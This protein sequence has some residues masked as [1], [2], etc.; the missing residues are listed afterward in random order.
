MLALVGACEAQEPAD[1]GPATT[2]ATPTTASTAST[3][4]T[5]TTTATTTTTSPTTT[6]TSPTSST[7]ATTDPEAAAGAPTVRC[8]SPEGYSVD[9]PE[10]WATNSGDVVPECG[11]FHPEPFDVTPGTDERVAAVTAFI[12]PVPFARVAALDQAEDGERAATVIDGLQAVRLEYEVQE[13]ALWPVGT[14]VTLYAVDVS[15]ETENRTLILDTVGLSQFEYERNQAVLDR[16]ARTLDIEMDGVSGDPE[17]VADYRGGGGG[18]SVEGAV[19]GNEACLRIPPA[20]EEVCTDLPA[21]D[22]L[23]TIQLEDLEPVVAGVTGDDVF[24]VTAERPDGTTSTVLPA[25]IGDRDSVGGFSFTFGLD[26]IERFV[27]S[28][29]EGAELRTIEPGG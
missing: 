27:L 6:S 5:T 18:F 4:T 11:Q 24:A 1:T 7:P 25:P 16:M 21:P 2:G 14:P 9:Y 12:D 13:D 17:V 10:A 19:S 8:D 26:Q 29:V 3:L 20:G 28:D 23:H 15:T 22:Q